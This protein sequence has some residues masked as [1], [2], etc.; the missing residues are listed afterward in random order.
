ML[1]DAA[2][3]A[4]RRMTLELSFARAFGFY[5]TKLLPSTIDSQFVGD[6]IPDTN[7]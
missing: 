6:G 1:D 4:M 2:T 5:L 3:L 7:F